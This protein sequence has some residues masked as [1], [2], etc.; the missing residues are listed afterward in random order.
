MD[1]RTFTLLVE[2][3]QRIEK[4]N[5]DQL[6]MLHDHHKYVDEARN[7]VLGQ[8]EI[9]QKDVAR[10]SVYFNVLGWIGTPTLTGIIG[11]LFTKLGL[12]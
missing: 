10:H 12:K 3:L 9:L 7:A 11:Y 5:D 1:E 6:A 2:R 8:V 4:Q